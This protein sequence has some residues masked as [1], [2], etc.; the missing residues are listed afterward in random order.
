MLGRV[1]FVKVIK[2]S[3]IIVDGFGDKKV[4]EDRVI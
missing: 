1:L 4:I 3:I 2:E